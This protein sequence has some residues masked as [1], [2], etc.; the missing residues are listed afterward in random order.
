MARASG[1]DRRDAPAGNDRNTSLQG[2]APTHNT[3]I[4]HYLAWQLA[5]KLQTLLHEMG[6]QGE[7]DNG[8]DTS[9]FARDTMTFMLAIANV[10]WPDEVGPQRYRQAIRRLLDAP[11]PKPGLLNRHP[12]HEIDAWRLET[13]LLGPA[14]HGFDGLAITDV[15]LHL[16]LLQTQ[17]FMPQY[18]RPDRSPEA[19]LA[20][21]ARRPQVHATD[22]LRVP[23]AVGQPA[24]DWTIRESLIDLWATIIPDLA[25]QC[26]DEFLRRGQAADAIAA[27][28]LESPETSDTEP[29]WTRTSTACNR[30][31]AYEPGNLAIQRLNIYAHAAKR[32]LA[33]VLRLLAA[34]LIVYPGQANF[35][36]HWHRELADAAKLLTNRGH[37][38]AV[39]VAAG[40]NDW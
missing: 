33:D 8:F 31:R 9:P 16:D 39:A 17:D 40:V 32:P 5:T 4:G 35:E 36:Q 24:V 13:G 7:S 10:L 34:G 27:L 30:L 19:L 11:G 18:P 38:A 12:H 26:P 22:G 21:D 23:Q 14:P 6:N 25:N 29:A 20:F 2:D 15:M 3:T 1:N 28:V 37:T